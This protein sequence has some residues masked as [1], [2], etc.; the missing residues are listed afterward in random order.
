LVAVV[1]TS[2]PNADRPGWV[3]AVSKDGVFAFAMPAKPV[4]KTVVQQSPNGP[5]EVLEYSCVRGDCLYRIEKAKSPIKIPDEK[6]EG[7]LAASR[8]AIARKTRVLVDKSTTVAGWPARQLT[9][10]AP[11][12]PGADSSTI[13]MLICYADSDFYQVR[14]FSL[15]PGTT[16]TDVRK[17]FDSFKPKK[18]RAKAEEK[19]KS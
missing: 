12:R 9:V 6:L 18:D 4:E 19:S 13:A 5:V 10:E 11:L 1:L 16:P 3:D 17:F 7:A 15:K 14:V 8:D 2:Q